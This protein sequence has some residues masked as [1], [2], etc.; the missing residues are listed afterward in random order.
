MRRT[1]DRLGCACSY[2]SC[3]LRLRLPAGYFP[4]WYALQQLASAS[5]F[6][7]C[8]GRP[9]CGEL[10]TRSWSR[11][12]ADDISVFD[13]PHVEIDPTSLHLGLEIR[14]R[15]AEDGVVVEVHRDGHPWP[16]PLEQVGALLAVHR[17]EEE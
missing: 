14:E 1:T 15:R 11:G 9:V 16:D 17:H 3:L 7:S 4:R 10:V 12:Q 5:M 13:V 6:R 8:N 2:Y